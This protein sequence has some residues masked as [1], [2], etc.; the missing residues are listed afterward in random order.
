MPLTLEQYI[1][2][3]D[4]RSDLPW[5]G[6]P[7]IDPPRAKPSLHPLPVKAVFWTVYGTLVAIPQGELQFE[8]PQDFITDAALDKL[9]KEFKMWNSMSRKPGAPSAY[10]KELYRKALTTLQL[11][12]GTPGERCP[13][14]QVERVWEDIIKK[15]FQKD[16]Q[17]DTTTYGSMNEYSK[18]IAYFYHA[19]IQGTGAYPGAVD[20][21]RLT[22]DRGIVQGLLG[23]G[24]C[25]TCG[26]LQKCLKQQD[27][28]FSLDA[29]IPPALRIISSEKKARKPSETLFRLAA[30]AAES[31]NIDPDEILHVGSSLVRDIAPAKKYGFRTALFAG[32]KNSLA[33]TPDQLKDAAFRPDV[34]LTEL[35]QIL[36]VF[37]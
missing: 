14:V 2:R 29:V 22:A 15:L 30:Q 31:K 27:P 6:A 10:M 26:Q 35:P 36:E 5:P 33:A 11:T 24:Q 17:F 18:K 20:A 13:E 12:G 7:K 21:L 28:G 3:L 37:G 8:H 23:D 25:F 34:L 19:S 32:D 9:I 16:Y 4:A 1:D